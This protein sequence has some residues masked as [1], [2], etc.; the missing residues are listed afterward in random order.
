MRS[1]HA[2]SARGLTLPSPDTEN[3]FGQSGSFRSTLFTPRRGKAAHKQPFLPA[4]PVPDLEVLRTPSPTVVQVCFFLLI[5]LFASGLILILK[6]YRRHNISSFPVRNAF[7]PGV[8]IARDLL[9]SS[10]IS[11]F[12][13]LPV[14]Q[15]W[16][17][18]QSPSFSSMWSPWKTIYSLVSLTIYLMTIHKSLLPTQIF[19]PSF[20]PMRPTTYQIFPFA[21]LTKCVQNQTPSDPRTHTPLCSLAR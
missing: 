3:V 7:C 8:N 11:G 13:C 20:R 10:Y 21:L 12:I 9:F 4:S 6:D 5:S 1:T 15:F 2:L 19:H 16:P 14:R 18:F 17:V